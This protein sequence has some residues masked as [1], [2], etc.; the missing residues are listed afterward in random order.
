MMFGS[1]EIFGGDPQKMTRL[2]DKSDCLIE[3]AQTKFVPNVWTICTITSNR[4]LDLNGKKDWK[5]TKLE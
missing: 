2:S 5:S 3:E 1:Y 4:L